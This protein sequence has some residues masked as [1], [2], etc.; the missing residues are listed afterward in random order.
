VKSRLTGVRRW[1]TAPGFHAGY[2]RADLVED[3]FQRHSL[4]PHRFRFAGVEF[5]RDLR[6]GARQGGSWVSHGQK[7]GTALQDVQREV[8]SP[9]DL[10]QQMRLVMIGAAQPAAAQGSAA[11][12]STGPS[13]SSRFS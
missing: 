3:R 5:G 6:K 11:G 13:A 10:D 9:Q 12:A 7:I 8:A 1:I 4:A 2:T